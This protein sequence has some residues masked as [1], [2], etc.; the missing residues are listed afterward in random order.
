MVEINQFGNQRT[1]CHCRRKLHALDELLTSL[2]S[3]IETA[4]EENLKE[5]SGYRAAAHA[6]A[7]LS[8]KYMAGGQVV[9]SRSEL[10][11]YVA[12]FHR[13]GYCA[14]PPPISMKLLTSSI[15]DFCE[16]R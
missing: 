12:E 9:P 5:I 11:S 13:G 10:E 4:K 16:D 3:S 7:F 14:M 6:S 8:K 15:L 1:G 2:V